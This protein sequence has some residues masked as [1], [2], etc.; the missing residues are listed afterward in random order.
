MFGLIF[1]TE[2][3]GNIKI[4]KGLRNLSWVNDDL[5]KSIATCRA[6]GIP[7]SNIEKLINT[8]RRELL[9]LKRK[10]VK[11]IK[12]ITKTGKGDKMFVYFY[13]AGHGC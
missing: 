1:I 8:N 4:G 7:E 6:F 10:M 13:F 12:E 11:R 9:N 5:K 3:Y 2:F